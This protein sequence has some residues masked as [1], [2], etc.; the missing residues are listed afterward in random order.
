MKIYE[1]ATAPN[2]RRVRI[3]L[4][5][6]NIEGIEFVELDIKRGDNL[7]ADFKKKN[8]LAKIPV[9]ELDDGT[10]ISESIAICR[11]FEE[12]NSDN[13]GYFSTYRDRF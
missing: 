6:K 7:S 11:Y 10:I 8:P 2:A 13:P 4:H 3:F 9:L 12:S 5:E 1:S